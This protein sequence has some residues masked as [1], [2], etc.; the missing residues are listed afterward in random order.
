M[1]NTF[2]T[3]NSIADKYEE[4]FPGK[5]K[6]IDVFNKMLPKN[7]TIIDVGCGTG[8]DTKYLLQKG[9]KVKSIDASSKMLKIAKKN[10]PKHKFYLCDIKKIKF[11]P[12]SADG[13]VAGF[14]IIHLSKKDNVIII[15]KFHRILT[16]SGLLYL[17]LQ[18]G[19]GEKT[20]YEPLDPRRKIFVN[21]YITDEI[22]NVLK[23]SGFKVVFLRI[24]GHKSKYEFKN[25][26]IFII[27]KKVNK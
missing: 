20:L 16:D 19:R 22:K 25:N 8:Y 26:K 3:Y 18:E 21:F 23:I 24:T 11:R 17:A 13:I 10:A 5:N 27:A 6:F 1:K 4:K 14:S 7:A 15:R 9:H 2:T 12:N